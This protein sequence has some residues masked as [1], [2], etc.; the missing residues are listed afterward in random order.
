MPQVPRADE[1]AAS[2]SFQ[3]S[4]P[5]N[6]KS[7]ASALK[8]IATPR[9]LVGSHQVTQR[10][11]GLDPIARE[12]LR[13]VET[14]RD[15]MNRLA[16]QDAQARPQVSA[17]LNGMAWQ[18][19]H[20]RAVIWESL[21]HTREQLQTALNQA[22]ARQDVSD[23]L[24]DVLTRLE[25]LAELSTQGAGTPLVAAAVTVLLKQSRLQRI[26]STTMTAALLK[27]LFNRRIEQFRVERAG[28]H[29]FL[30]AAGAPKSSSLEA[31]RKRL[32]R[33]PEQFEELA[34]MQGDVP[35]EDDAL[36]PADIKTLD[37]MQQLLAHDVQI[38][39][40]RNYLEQLK[41][42][43]LQFNT[44]PMG[45][46]AA[47]VKQELSG[48]DLAAVL[49]SFAAAP[50]PEAHELFVEAERFLVGDMHGATVTRAV[51]LLAQ[52]PRASRPD[53]VTL[54]RR[55]DP[56][57]E[58]GDFMLK[59]LQTI[60]PT[61]RAAVVNAFTGPNRSMSDIYVIAND[62]LNRGST[63]RAAMV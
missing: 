20:D 50:G 5:A 17:A 41:N 37:E 3:A 56:R 22:I 21:A 10:P 53:L 45:A 1:V 7:L 28:L 42:M 43:I 58:S 27:T 25:P 19:G 51:I 11:A 4:A 54:T 31:A 61:R 29:T 12:S 2:D 55:L 8:A 33:L 9:P 47:A 26:V 36:H 48:V 24:S 39:E 40:S 38:F 34:A 30:Q 49:E 52:E 14:L 23:P 59:A 35:S 32:A 44:D 57:G 62:I 46:R 6:G 13:D 60:P 16:A 18:M 15:D 63:T